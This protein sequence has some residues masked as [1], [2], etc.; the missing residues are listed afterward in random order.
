MSGKVL[1][2]ACGSDEDIGTVG[3]SFVDFFEYIGDIVGVG[4]IAL[5]CRDIGNLAIIAGGEVG[6][7]LLCGGNGFRTV[8][9]EDGDIGTGLEE[10]LGHDIA[11]TAG[12][13]GN[14]C[15]LAFKGES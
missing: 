9:I 3:V 10:S 2:E 15:G 8:E 11:E 12:T 4:D 5:M 14:D 6:L 7:E 1:T 13:A